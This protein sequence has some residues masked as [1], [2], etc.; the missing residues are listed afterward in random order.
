[1]T[2][3]SIWKPVWGATVELPAH[4]LKQME[5]GN[6]CLVLGAGCSLTSL[7]GARERIPSTKGFC[8]VVCEAAG[9]PYA[10]ETPKDVFQAVRAPS[11]PLSSVDLKKLFVD[12][13]T[14]C[15]PAPEMNK[16][17][18]FSWRRIYTFNID[19]VL[20]HTNR[21]S[22]VQTLRHVNAMREART[23]WKNFTECQVV[24]LHGFAGEF[25]NGVIFSR[26]EYAKETHKRGRWYESIGE[27]FSN[28]TLLVVGSSLDEPV[29]D[30]HIQTFA[31]SYSEG[32]RSYLI[33]PS[34]PSEIRK[35]SLENTGFVHL[36]GDVSALVNGLNGA[37]PQ[38]LPPEAI[39]GGVPN[40]KQSALT[41]DDIE[42]LRSFV[43]IDRASITKTERFKTASK[44]TLARKFFDGYGPEALHG[45]FRYSRN[46][47]T[48][49][50]AGKESVGTHSRKPSWRLCRR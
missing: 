18:G 16:I 29:L 19:D 31:D 50:R 2:I 30:Y 48:G 42:G 24:Y 28:H 8:K 1:M 10:G 12:H 45:S 6:V 35:R 3:R 38:G 43:P 32:G 39:K 23:E 26:E 34:Q 36:E 25:E 22:R 46:A 27:D 41:A 15:I 33:A 13:F 17:V 11:G 21:N 20:K 47:W 44:V 7:N 49:Y 4:L 5:N 9:L 37:F 14:E 40:V